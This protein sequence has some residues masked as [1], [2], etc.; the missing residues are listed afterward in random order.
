MAHY[1]IISALALLSS[2]NIS[3]VSAR[4][5]GLKPRQADSDL[6]PIMFSDPLLEPNIVTTFP[7]GTWIENLAIRSTDGNIIATAL[8]VPEVYLISAKNEFEPVLLAEFP[9]YL[10]ALGI[11]ELGHDVFYVVVGN[12]S[13]TTA[14]AVPGSFS[15]WE[16]T[17]DKPTHQKHHHWA[18]WK[19]TKG[20]KPK[21][22][23]E[24]PGAG[25]LNGLTVLNP[26]GSILLVADSLYGTVYS[27]NVRTGENSI[28]INDPSLAPQ[29]DLSGGLAIGINGL[30]ARDGYVYFDNTNTV[31]FNRIPVNSLT[32]E[33]TGDVEVLIDQEFANIFP[34]DFTLDAAGNAWLA[35]QWGHVA[36]LEGVMAGEKMN[37]TAVAGNSTGLPHGLTAAQ[38]GITAEDLERGSLYVTSNGDPYSYGTDA[39]AQ[40]QLIRYDTAVLGLF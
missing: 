11:V 33:P 19:G 39:P 7:N 24:F 15:V 28:V 29:P 36:Y 4:L 5:P 9:G 16:L 34:D 27:L 25:L 1:T 35:C 40:G 8:S 32:G 2:F 21:L 37:I 17:F 22:V 30:S 12:Y 3:P 31:T 10:G 6:T 20:E 26:I 14:T 23:A 18:D 38:F 13:V